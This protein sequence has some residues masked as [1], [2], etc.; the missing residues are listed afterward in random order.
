M[1]AK[2]LKKFF[3]VIILK[4]VSFQEDSIDDIMK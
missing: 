3:E 4:L 2:L 1:K